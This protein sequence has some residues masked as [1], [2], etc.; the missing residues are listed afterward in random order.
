[1]AA[2]HITNTEFN[3]LIQ[4]DKPILVDFWAPWCVY[5]K[6]INSAYDKIAESYADK[7]TVAKVNIDDEPALAEQYQIELV[8]TLLFI[9]KGEV[10]GSITAPD[11]KARIEAFIQENLEK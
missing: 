1:M 4:G 6:R 11:S 2:I 9:K 10:L 7:V 8:P 5:C 3:E